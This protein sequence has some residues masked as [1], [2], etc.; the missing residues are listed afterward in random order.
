MES[1]LSKHHELKEKCQSMNKSDQK[2]KWIKKVIKHLVE[3]DGK[4]N[5]KVLFGAPRH[6]IISRI[7][8]ASLCIK[9]TE[10]K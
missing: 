10:K 2:K 1:E 5:Q 4:N 3:F 7:S 9:R 8:C 6:I